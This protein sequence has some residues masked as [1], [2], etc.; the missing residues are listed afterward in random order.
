LKK[1]ETV[2][3]GENHILSQTKYTYNSLGWLVSQEVK[4]SSNLHPG[5]TVNFISTTKYDDVG[6]PTSKTLPDGERIAYRYFIDDTEHRKLAAIEKIN[7]PTWLDWLILPISHIVP[8]KW[9][10]KTR[11]TQFESEKLRDRQN[12]ESD[13]GGFMETQVNLQAGLSAVRLGQEFD[14]A[15]LPQTLNTSSVSLKLLWDAAGQ[16]CEI[17]DG[18]K[19]IARYSYDAQ[20]RRVSKS[21]A[22]G[23]SYYFYEGTQLTAIAKENNEGL[24]S[25]ESEYVYAGYQVIAWFQKKNTYTLQTDNRGAVQSVSNAV[26]GAVLWTSHI[27]ADGLVSANLHTKLDPGLRLVNQYYDDESGLHYNVGRYYDPTK[28]RFISPDPM[29]IAD[30]IDHLTPDSL[31][32]DT[33]IYAAGQPDIFFDPDGAAKLIYYA[34]TTDANGKSLGMNQGFT[35]ARWAFV[36]QDVKAINIVNNPALSALNKKYAQNQT[37]TLVDKGGDFINGGKV[38]MT[39]DDRALTNFFTEHYGSNLISTPQFT[40]DHFDDESATMLIAKFNQQDLA[41]LGQC[42]AVPLLL[43]KI[44]FAGEEPSIDVTKGDST[45]G[46]TKQRIL[47]CGKGASDDINQ[48]R[49][50]KYEAAAEI[51]E[52]ARINRDCSVDGCPGIGYYCDSTKC[53]PP[54]D[55]LAYGPPNTSEPVYT[56]SYGRSQFIGTTLLNELIIGFA[57]FSQSDKDALGLTPTMKKSLQEGLQRG[58]SVGEWRKKIKVEA[59]YADANAAWS[60][61]SVASQKQFTQETGLGERE[62]TDMARITTQPPKN[63]K[64]KN[65]SGDA[66]AAFAT[67]A[68]MT[69][70]SL[71]QYLIGIITNFDKFTIMGN[72]LMKKI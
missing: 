15:G 42:P 13:S 54:R 53:Y 44:K 64:G 40:V 58:N 60:K 35:K 52:T 71:K 61:L 59:T 12:I 14:N 66:W 57:H 37:T 46:A 34:I 10:P 38:S 33:T 18:N 30:S 6:N 28:G 43:P 7:W 26:T 20:G 51:N 22:K 11:L 50:S 39:M 62:F 9:L 31:K 1:T 24:I 48:R 47:A 41:T 21:T 65:L 4:I 27:N 32:L 56:P 70:T 2:S 63:S 5:K 67:T 69:N 3:N 8:D 36:I 55:Q 68:I 29:G 49:I 16:L 19:I 23:T 72:A 45:N 25:T 17:K